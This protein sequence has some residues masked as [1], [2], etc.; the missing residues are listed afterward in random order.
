MK[1]TR[2]KVEGM[3]C[4]HCQA[5]V[6]GALQELAGVTKAEVNLTE[7]IV[8]VTYDEQKVTIAAMEDAV[9]QQGY[10]IG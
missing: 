5:S 10:D 4:G 3:T 6:E 9:E 8:D 2:L 7:G 1:Q